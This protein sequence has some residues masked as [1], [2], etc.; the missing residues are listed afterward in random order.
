MPQE[1]DEFELI[2]VSPLRRLEK[3]LERME[4]S[5]KSGMDTGKFFSELVEIVRMNQE[6]VDE[7][8]K[9]NDALRIEISK[10]PGR[11][12][13][14]ITSVNELVAFI[15]A[16][17]GADAIAGPGGMPG[18]GMEPLLKKMDELID[19]NK[20]IVESNE[21]VMGAV[22]QLST[23]FKRPLMPL[24]PPLRRMQ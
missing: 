12:D 4:G 8:A 15:K 5:A 16:S 19:A 20:K 10:L 23:K 2:P 11:L 24:R 3:R 14:L 18:A 1:E 17:A 7:L 6:L 13:D 21:A 9:A 22:D